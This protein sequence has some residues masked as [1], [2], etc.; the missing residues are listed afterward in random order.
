MTEKCLS[1]PLTPELLCTSL[2]VSLAFYTELL[3]FIV[4]YRSLEGGFAMLERN[5]SLIMLDEIAPGSA[6]NWTVAPLEAPFGRGINLRMETEDVD[7]LYAR[8][9][10]TDAKIFLPIE[11]T[12]YRGDDFDRGNRQF[13]VQDPDGY[14]LRFFQNLGQRKR[15]D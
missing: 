7:G 9:K 8:L 4:Q 5:G 6:E 15:M 12:W 14:L 1:T 10:E 11:E 3:G 13:I 2:K